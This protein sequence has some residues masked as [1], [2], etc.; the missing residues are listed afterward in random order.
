[1]L[2]KL[3]FQYFL[4]LDYL[5]VDKFS[6][7][8]ILSNSQSNRLRLGYESRMKKIGL[9][10][11]E[12]ILSTL[13][14]LS[15][16]KD[17]VLV[18]GNVFTVFCLFYIILYLF[19]YILHPFPYFFGIHKHICSKNVFSPSFEYHTHL[20]FTALKTEILLIVN[21][22]FTRILAHL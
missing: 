22:I 9:I 4:L 14:L 13:S 17:L 3:W 11:Y 12:H 15:K 16:V 20:A 21:F 18:K 2:F 6:S 19:V 5:F 10:T 7:C 1:M 8:E